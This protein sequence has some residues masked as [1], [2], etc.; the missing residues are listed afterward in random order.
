MAIST[1][2]GSQGVTLL[3][4]NTEGKILYP[5]TLD[6]IQ[7]LIQRKGAPSKLTFKVMNDKVLNFEEGH[8]VALNVN[9]VDAFAGYVFTKSRD[10]DGVISVTAYDQIRYLKNKGVLIYTHKKASDVVTM[11]ANDFNLR[12]G[13]TEDTQYIIPKRNES[14][15]AMIDMI[16][17][18][19]DLTLQNTKK[20]Y[21]FY[22]DFG[23]LCL[24]STE[25]LLVNIVIDEETAENY[26]YES[27]IDKQTYNQVK[28]YFDNKKTGKREL[29]VTK[30]S[31]NQ[32]K[33]GILQLCESLNERQTENAAA[34]A[35]ALLRLYN[36]KSRKLNIKNAF[37]DIRVRG[38]SGV[39]VK[40]N[41][42]DII[43]DKRMLVESVTHNFQDNQHMMD[44]ELRGGDID[45]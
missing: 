12:V 23:K 39:W 5:A 34:K 27:S 40:L 9:G 2:T 7:W 3:I 8:L 29:Y 19:L 32:I 33:W 10:K 26:N 17:Y 6:G 1:I 31:N 28:L 43:V 15:V 45:E 38:G 13:E 22:D 20:M 25:N 44:L 4:Q 14:N 41:L 21:V 16:Q 24:K 42:G 30:D 35:D 37:G 36:R 11:L 18:A